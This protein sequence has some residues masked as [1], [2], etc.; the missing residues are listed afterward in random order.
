MNISSLTL[1]M[2][3]D[4]NFDCDYCYQKKGNTY[5]DTSTVETALDFFSPYLT[6]ECYIN[7]YGGEPL[8]AFKQI[9][10]VVETIKN[11]LKKKHIIFT[12]S[13]NGIL[14][15]DEKL[16]FL[17]Q[18][19]FS[20]LLSFDGFAQNIHRKIGS[21]EPIVAIIKKLLECPDIDLEINSV[22]T[23]KTIG[24]LSKSVQFIA[25]LNVQEISVALSQKS[26]WNHFGLLQYK[27][28]LQSLKNYMLSF[29][30][31]NGYTPFMKFR[32]DRKRGVFSCYAARDR[33]AITADGKIWGCHLF[34]DFYNGKKSTKEYSKYC[35]GDL[36]SFIEKSERVYPE[37]SANYSN[38]RMDTFQ[39][40]DSL[41]VDCEEM[42]ECKVC[43]MDN[44]IHGSS[45]KKIPRWICEHNKI[46]REVKRDFWKELI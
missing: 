11:K 4:C 39:T 21:F 5:M 36:H 27:K 22:F 1:Y 38:F 17:N 34:A 29:Y 25:E 15:N 28:E 3:D 6:K 13:T 20:I 37:I 43:P 23:P 26:S 18:N 14:L 40:E 19:K 35:F 16:E 10:H 30:L 42:E 32:K 33:L 31:Q 2:T 41:C 7:F 44:R 8:M 12:I 9:H 46:T 24:Y 45:F